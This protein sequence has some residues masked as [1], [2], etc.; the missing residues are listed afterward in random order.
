MIASL[1]AILWTSHLTPFNKP[2]IKLPLISSPEIL[3]KTQ[4]F[5]LLVFYLDVY[6]DIDLRDLGERYASS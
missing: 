4:L 1:D 6:A 5:H 3:K 2:P